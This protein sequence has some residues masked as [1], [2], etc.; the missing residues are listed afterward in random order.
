M[1]FYSYLTDFYPVY[2]Q[3]SV[4]PGLLNKLLK[5]VLCNVSASR[6]VSALERQR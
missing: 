2:L 6:S 3:I 1:N 5:D 4:E